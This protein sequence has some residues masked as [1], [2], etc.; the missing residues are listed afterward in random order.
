VFAD[1]PRSLLVEQDRYLL[2]LVRYVHNNPVRAGVVRYARNSVWSSHQAYVGRGEAPEW[3]RVGYVLERFRSTAERAPKAFDEFV[4]QGRTQG[5]RPELSGASD[6]GEA[7]AVRRTLGDGYR[8]S[9]GVLGST[10]FVSRVRKDVERVGAARLSRGKEQRQGA[11]GRPPVREVIDAVLN[12]QEL[13]PIELREKPRTRA[14]A[15]AKRLAIWVWV[16]E[17]RGRQ[18]EVARALSLDTSVVS[19]YYGQALQRPGDFDERATAVVALLRKS[20]RDTK[21]RR[22]TRATQGGFPVRYSVD[23]EEN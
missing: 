14:A 2:E 18:I 21:T 1:R 4:D 5:R 22:M 7:A 13:D 12:L 16:R 10:D 23:V 15:Q 17:Y 20:R 19:R 6:S 9:D 3:L 11:I 8:V